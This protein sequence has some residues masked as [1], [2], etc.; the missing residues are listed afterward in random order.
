MH[1]YRSHQWD[2]CILFIL[3]HQQPV[4]YTFIIDLSFFIYYLSLSFLVI[5]VKCYIR[6]CGVLVPTGTVTQIM[7]LNL[8]YIAQAMYTMQGGL[9][10]HPL[11][12]GDSQLMQE[13]NLIVI[14]ACRVSTADPHCT[15]W[16]HDHIYQAKLLGS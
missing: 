15:C 2:C 6:P 3:T 4:I 7:N 10:I 11:E 12:L 9:S 8:V 14:H 13:G 1:I 16:V 5:C